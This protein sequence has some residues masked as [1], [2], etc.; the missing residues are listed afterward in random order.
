V[1][2]NG[3]AHLAHTIAAGENRRFFRLLSDIALLRSRDYKTADLASKSLIYRVGSAVAVE[4][5]GG[6]LLRKAL[7]RHQEEGHM[8]SGSFPPR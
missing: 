6:F 5:L 4:H 2:K 1:A 8:I 3:T 7:K